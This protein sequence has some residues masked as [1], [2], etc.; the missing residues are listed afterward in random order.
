MRIDT[1]YNYKILTDAQGCFRVARLYD[2]GMVRFVSPPYL[3]ESSARKWAI[4]RGYT[5][6]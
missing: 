3:K 6:V 1:N 2:G 5:L 4:K